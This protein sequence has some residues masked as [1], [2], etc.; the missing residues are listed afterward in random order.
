MRRY[1]GI[2]CTIKMSYDLH[3][4]PTTNPC[5]KTRCRNGGICQAVKKEGNKSL[6]PSLPSGSKS[7]RGQFSGQKRLRYD[8]KR[9]K[10]HPKC[11]CPKQYA[12][13][14]CEKTNLCLDKCLNGGTC[15]WSK[16]NIVSCNCKKGFEGENCEGMKSAT[17][18]HN[19]Q[20]NKHFGNDDTSDDTD[21]VNHG[22]TTV[23]GV[24]MCTILILVV[25]FVLVVKCRSQRLGHAFRHRR[26]AESLLTGQT[27]ASRDVPIGEFPNQMFLEEE[28]D[29]IEEERGSRG[30]I[31]RSKGH[32]RLKS[33]PSHF[34]GATS[35]ANFVNPVYQN[36]YGEDRHDEIQNATEIVDESGGTPSK[37]Q[38]EDT[39]DS[40]LLIPSSSFNEHEDGE[41][42]CDTTSNKTKMNR[43]HAVGRPIYDSNVPE[44]SA[45]FE[46][47]DL[48]TEKHRGNIKL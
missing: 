6:L 11:I 29:D 24:I 39:E 46:S 30:G 28:P 42:A 10:Y 13:L 22:V 25:A 20:K 44:E 31:I 41:E 1:T 26:M 5:A 19:H 14:L 35:S 18:N 38:N 2:D 8:Y 43:R 16:E 21:A 17:T 3:G 7:K 47:A 37:Q 36:I 23:L 45:S 34:G 48:L 32:F 4:T 9:K 12:G 40:F 27:S 15:E 33:Q